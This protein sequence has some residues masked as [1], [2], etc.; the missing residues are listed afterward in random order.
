MWATC[1]K[2]LKWSGEIY[3]SCTRNPTCWIMSLLSLSLPL[4]RFPSSKFDICSLCDLYFTILLFCLQRTL[5]QEIATDIVM[6]TWSFPRMTWIT[7]KNRMDRVQSNSRVLGGIRTA[8]IW[9]S[10]A[11][12]QRGP[13][14]GLMVKGSTSAGLRCCLGSNSWIHPRLYWSGLSNLCYLYIHMFA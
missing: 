3:S 4:H 1:K 5:S 12:T 8:S 11:T 7:T 10:M 13:W 6:A 14:G 2:P 9:T